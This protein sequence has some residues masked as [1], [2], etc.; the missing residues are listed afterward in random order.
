MQKSDYFSF[1]ALRLMMMDSFSF[2]ECVNRKLLTQ[3][4]TW[5]LKCL[6]LDVDLTDISNNAFQAGP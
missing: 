1:L 2:A 4:D 6:D 3:M 5:V